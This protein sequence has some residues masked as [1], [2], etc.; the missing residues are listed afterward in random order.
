[1]TKKSQNFTDFNKNFESNLEQ[2]NAEQ[3]AA[4]EQIEGPVMV[5]AGPGTGKTHILAARIG[6]ILTET[7][8]SAQNILCLTFT[9][10]GVLAMRKRLLQLIGSEGQRVH[11]FTFHG[12]CS[13]VI[14]DNAEQFGRNDLEPL[15][16]LENLDILKKILLELPATHPLSMASDSDFYVQHLKNLFQKMKAEAWTVESILTAIDDY[17]TE[18]PNKSEYIYQIKRGAS[19]KGD[20]KK[21]ILEA[22]KIKMSLLSAAVQLFPRYEYHLMASRRFDFEDMIGWV[23]S[24]FQ[25]NEMLLRTYQERYLYV[26]VDEFQDTNGAQN[27]LI[28]QLIN[29]W[30]SP[31]IFIVG[32]DDQAIYEFQGARLKSLMDFFD[33]FRTEIKLVVLKENYR[34]T[35][36]ILDISTNLISHNTVRIVSYLDGVEKKLLAAKQ[37]ILS[38]PKLPQINV[39]Q[40]VIEESAAIVEQIFQLQMKG[41]S[42][43]EIAIIYNKHKQSSLIIR[44][45]ER[46]GIPY[47][48]K[49]PINILD[50]PLMQQVST[51]LQYVEAELRQPYSGESLIFRLMY[52]RFWDIS[53]KD[54][55]ALSFAIGNKNNRESTFFWRDALS[56]TAFLEQLN[57]ANNS[58]ISNFVTFFENLIA[59]AAD[60]P[61][62][63]LVE[64]LLNRSGWLSW[65]MQQPQKVWNLQLL[66]TLYDFLHKETTRNPNLNLSLFVELLDKMNA[67][68]LSLPIQKTIENGKGVTLLT[69]HAAKG[70]EFEYVFVID[71]LEESWGA[72]RANTSQFKLPDT[73]TFSV[74]QDPEEARRRLFYVALTR[75]KTHLSISYSLFSAAGKEQQRLSFIDEIHNLFSSIELINN[76]LEMDELIETHRLLLQEN[77]NPNYIEVTK[78]QLEKMLEGFALSVTAFNSF[79]RCPLIFYHEHVLRLPTAFSS[80]AVFGTA[81]HA[82]LE[83]TAMKIRTSKEKI[84]PNCDEIKAQFKHYLQKQRARLSAA[85]FERRLAIGLQLLEKYYE[86]E[87][88]KWKKIL[89][90]EYAIR[91]V[92]IQGVPITGT[93]DKIELL[94]GNVAN[95]VDYKT[96]KLTLEAVAARNPKKPKSIGGDYWRQLYFYKILYEASRQRQVA[97]ASGEISYVSL[98]GKSEFDRKTV[99]FTAE[100]E[101]FVKNL[102]LETYHKIMR[103]EFD[104]GCEKPNCYWCNFVRQQHTT[105]DTFNDGNAEDLDDE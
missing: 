53:T 94:E 79:L 50:E 88:P 62:H 4:V 47:Q 20:L 26:L 7:D 37:P 41:V 33:K 104:K 49:K 70:L 81:I 57:L 29:Y 13:T 72:G 44:L 21:A 18:L 58:K 28:Q 61:I 2:L 39:Y 40:T 67:Q 65:L 27:A 6:R 31:N 69:A 14:R 34:S 83:W 91:A 76:S 71:A 48:T 82:T 68:K 64:R 74:S 102:M 3:R 100:D 43:P 51:A 46:R 90:F 85:D 99:V 5:I 9:D 75:A 11:V 73:L 17:V 45:L 55:A 22:E 66:N 92:E 86:Q 95:I 78:E 16:E 54:L 103:F 98:N 59:E 23:L 30:D 89:Q 15:S 63:A 32:D 25:K 19:Q 8:T 1:M 87:L 84:Y 77:E 105:P 80:N 101:H 60:L 35:Q 24:A 10:A 56:D 36:P 38:E 96:G 93:I 12:F 42:L 52:L 97:V